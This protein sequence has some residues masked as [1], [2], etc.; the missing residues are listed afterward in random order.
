MT[1]G[2]NN[3]FLTKPSDQVPYF[4]PKVEIP[5]GTQVENGEVPIP[6]LFQP[7]KIKNTQFVNRIGVSP[8]CTY[9]SAHAG[10]DIGCATAFHQTHYG[11]FALQGPGM[12]I[13]EATAIDP[14]GRLSPEDLGIWNDDQALSL[15]KFVQFAHAQGVKIGIQLGHGGRK[16]SGTA[17][18]NHLQKGIG[19]AEFGWSDIPGAIVGPSPISF[20][21]RSYVTPSELTID[22]IQDLVQKFG[23]AAKRAR[24]ISGFD[25]VEIHAAH[26]YLLSSFLSGTSNKRTD[27]YGGSFENRIRFLLEVVDAVK[28]DTTPLFVRVSG[29][30]LAPH[31]EGSWTIEDTVKLSDHLIE[32]GVD[33]LD[34]SSGG[35]N[36][37]AERRKTYQGFQ[38]PLAK[39]VKEHVG[40]KLLI[41]T[42]GKID[43]GE[44]ANDTLEA[45]HADIVLSGRA[46]LK[47]PGLVWKW[48]DD[49][50]VRIKHS[51]QYEWPF[52]PPPFK[53]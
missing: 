33:V 5:L 51:K 40:N 46:F 25:F 8:M 22:Q 36:A 7:F 19:K 24:E 28:D 41:A 13:V 43:Q 14:N 42:V 52:Y 39:A 1:S 32:H 27:Q 37:K 47:N 17:I 30:E 44:F 11:S 29:S 48:A 50:G 6:K 35:N 38:V 15:K 4:H 23:D 49:L 18:Y 9:S 20:S 21:T 34:I 10:P 53:L 12:I 3:R 26:G 2:E 31:I 16:A 45:G